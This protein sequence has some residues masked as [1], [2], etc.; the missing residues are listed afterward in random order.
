MYKQKISMSKEGNMYMVR[1]EK[2]ER[3]YTVIAI[4][5]GN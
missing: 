5:T 3:I 2:G 4:I 1:E